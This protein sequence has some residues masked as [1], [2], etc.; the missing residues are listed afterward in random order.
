VRKQPDP[1]V[2]GALVV[3]ACSLA[4][5]TLLPS[6]SASA[7]ATNQDRGV[8]AFRSRDAVLHWNAVLL[9]AC[10]ND[11]DPAV[12]S[13]PDQKGPGRTARAFA[14]VHA[15]IFDAVNSIDRSYTPYL[16]LVKASRGASIKASVA[17]A[18]HDTLVALYPH[19]KAVFDAALARSLDGIAPDGATR[20]VEVGRAAAG[21]ILA[22]RANDGSQATTTY[23]P[24]PLPGYHQPDPLH[25]NQGFLDPVWGT[26]TPFTMTNGAQFLAPDFVG[27]DPQ[28]RLTWLNSADYTAAF[29]EVKE[30]GGKN[31]TARTTDQTEIG[32]FWSYDGSPRIGTPPCLY[33]QITR[34]IA[35]Q[36][37]NT[38]VE[39]ARLFALV[40]LAMGDAGISCWG[41]KYI[42]QFWRPVVGIREAV[43]T[44]N[45][46]TAADATWEPLGAQADNNS[47]TNFTPNFPSYT[48]GHATFGSALFQ[49]LRRFYDT[50]DIPFRFQS[51]E[52]NGVTRD[53]AGAVRPR[54]TR[55]YLNLT[56]AEMENHDS[57]IYL[58]V[59]WRFDQHQGLIHGRSI[60]N[61]VIDNYLLP[62]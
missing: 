38:E 44:G 37:G 18:A 56:Q 49:V 17:Q 13:P 19:Q 48:S 46:A 11:F 12:V 62:R 5:G 36:M 52:F 1:I 43:S 42:Y 9:Q 28:F 61:F 60:G 15:A 6:G 27:R 31:S 58:G 21:N 51:D 25:P 40:N 47:G 4:E 3:F 59:H 29:N 30:L 53:D 32:I 8:A 23:T 24:V 45:S 14:I 54:R 55:H 26:I 41:C 57:R 20:G 22:A 7:Q 35:R 34:T 10:A 50:D 39:N 16:A 2:T 33:N